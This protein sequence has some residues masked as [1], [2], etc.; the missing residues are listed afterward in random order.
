MAMRPLATRQEPSLVSTALSLA[1]YP[2][3]Y[4]IHVGSVLLTWT[5]THLSASMQLPLRLLVTVLQIAD[6]LIC[7]LLA[8]V[9]KEPG[10]RAQVCCCETTD[11]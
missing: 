1:L 5:Y 10:L 6:A 11:Q 3:V 9:T 2:A 4:C 8:F 7:D